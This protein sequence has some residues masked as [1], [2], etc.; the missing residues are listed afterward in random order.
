MIRLL[1]VGVSSQ[2][3]S[4]L[5]AIFRTPIIIGSLGAKDFGAYV[6]IIG[7]WAV[8]AAV[9]EG[10]RAN[11]RQNSVH[12]IPNSKMLALSYL[13]NSWISV[14][15]IIPA[16]AILSFAAANNA[17]IVDWWLLLV[18]ALL[19]F[20]YPFFA[21]AV[22]S[23]ESQGKF[24]WFH[25][26]IITGQ[27]GSIAAILYLAPTKNVY[28]FA[29]ATLVPAF[30]PGVVAFWKLR[31]KTEQ[32]AP[33]N[34]HLSFN[35]FY[36]L[37]LVFETIAFSLD[38][39]IL[40]AMIGPTAAAEFAVTQRLMVF[41]SIVPVVL[42]PLIA[43]QGSR[44][45]SE[46]WLKRVRLGQTLLAVAIS[47]FLLLFSSFIFSFLTKGLLTFNPM[48]VVVGC[49]N[50]VIGVFASTTIQSVSSEEFIRIRFLG[51]MLLVLLSF[52]VT[53]T[54][55]PFVGPSSAFIG[56][57]AGTILYWAIIRK[58]KSNLK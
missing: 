47:V 49:I 41:F 43:Y 25:G 38:S 36:A 56:T 34:T 18:V 19:G 22:G 52:I 17:D 2:I 13:R 29:I 48:L 51:S 10:Y 21:G 50:G 12:K 28:I 33:L 20:L 58:A 32:D 24:T 7:T 42:A 6:S 3:I 53:V 4:A 37:V 31:K 23:V 57:T 39:A 5:V 54:L 9:G 40:L 16:L 35:H 27:M 30:I 14:A 46:G 15:A 26:A 55:V 11:L 8:L 1:S 45:G 44:K